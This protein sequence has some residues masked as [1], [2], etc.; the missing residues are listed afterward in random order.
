MK[1]SN[2]IKVSRLAATGVA[3]H[4]RVE[5]L[6]TQLRRVAVVVVVLSCRLQPV[7]AAAVSSSYLR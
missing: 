6:A 4:H 3:A 1:F 5:A 7:A 2:A